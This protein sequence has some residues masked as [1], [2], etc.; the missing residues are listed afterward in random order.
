MGKLFLEMQT[1]III[2]SKDYFVLLIFCAT[3][4]PSGYDTVITSCLK[5]LFSLLPE[6]FLF[7]KPGNLSLEMWFVLN[8][9]L[10]FSYFLYFRRKCHSVLTLPVAQNLS[11]LS[12]WSYLSAIFSMAR[13]LKNVLFQLGVPNSLMRI[14]IF[15][16]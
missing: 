10:M 8:L 11:L 5:R 13:L 7:F 15:D 2:K 9:S 3:H 14:Y 12:F 6:W 16:I 4:C 1:M